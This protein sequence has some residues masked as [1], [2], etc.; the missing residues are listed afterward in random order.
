MYIGR[1]DGIFVNHGRDVV[2]H[3]GIGSL[4]S[5]II[6]TTYANAQTARLKTSVGKD[7]IGSSVDKKTQWMSE[8]TEM[9][10]NS[11]DD[12][13]AFIFRSTFYGTLY[14][15]IGVPEDHPAYGDHYAW[16]DI[17]AH[18]EWA[19][20]GVEN[21]LTRRT[22]PDCFW[23]SFRCN[24]ADDYKPYRDEDAGDPENYRDIAYVTGLLEEAREQLLQM[25]PS[26]RPR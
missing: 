26:M 23:A 7:V 17:P 3:E 16:A 1:L 21:Y 24:Y 15:Y 12:I 6:R 8:P 9:Y 13:E 4:K 14:G 10:F 25:T 22:Q 2:H 5:K 19:T 18:G 20:E 11:R